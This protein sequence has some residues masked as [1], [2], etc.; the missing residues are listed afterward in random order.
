MI[1]EVF[2]NELC[3]RCFLCVR[4]SFMNLFFGFSIVRNMVVLVC[5]F[6]WGCILVYFVLKIFFR[7]LMVICLFW[8]IIL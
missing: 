8:F 2:I 5:V 3:E 1:F 7:W 6:E 4:F